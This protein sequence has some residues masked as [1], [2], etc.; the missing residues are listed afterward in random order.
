M[1][2]RNELS[3]LRARNRNAH[4]VN[5]VVETSFQKRKHVFTGDTLHLIGFVVVLSEL[6]FEYAVNSLG[7]L[8]FTKLKSVFG[9]LLSVRSVLSGRNRAFFERAGRFIALIPFKE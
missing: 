4:S 5:D 6:F 9:N 7:L 2:V 1:S 8:F 3:C